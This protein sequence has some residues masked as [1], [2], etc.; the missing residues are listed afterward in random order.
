MKCFILST[1]LLFSASLGL[2]S[3]GVTQKVVKFDNKY[4]I[5]EW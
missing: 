4:Y 3:Q 2:K 5:Q 1:I